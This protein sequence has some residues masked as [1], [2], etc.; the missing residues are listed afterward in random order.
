MN[1]CLKEIIRAVAA[2]LVLFGA[3]SSA[4]R[5]AQAPKKVTVGLMF[6]MTGAASPI[7]LDRHAPLPETHKQAGDHG[8]IA[9]V[10]GGYRNLNRST[11]LG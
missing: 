7:I 4:G 6:G 1:N 2:V 5:A 3:G 8:L 11:P 10:I 9:L